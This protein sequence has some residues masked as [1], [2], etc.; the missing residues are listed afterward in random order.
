[1]DELKK[2]KVLHLSLSIDVA[3]SFNEERTKIKSVTLS[4]SKLGELFRNQLVDKES[5]LSIDTI[6]LVY[7]GNTKVLVDVVSD[8]DTIL[9][10][11][12]N[13]E[14]KARAEGKNLFSPSGFEFFLSEDQQI[15]MPQ[16]KALYRINEV[17]QGVLAK[18][19]AKTKARRREIA[20]VKSK[21]VQKNK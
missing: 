12:N 6:G 8:A 5:I 11:V 1:M 14:T 7:G 18:R 19:K 17:H 2:K 13:Q 3:L 9:L 15:S 4:L 16:L 10:A 20:I 21:Q